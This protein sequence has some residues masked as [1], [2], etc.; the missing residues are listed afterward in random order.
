MVKAQLEARLVD[1]FPANLICVLIDSALASKAAA[2]TTRIRLRDETCFSAYDLEQLLQHEAFVHSH[3]ALNGRAQSTISC[4]GLGAP[5]N[6]GAQEGL[7]SFAE[8]ITGAIDIDRMERTALRV[9]G[10]D[11]AMRGATSSMCSDISLI[12]D[13][14]TAKASTRPCVYSAARR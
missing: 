5:R 9:V 12:P 14:R 4:L 10:T 3:T 7:A 8:L 2:G 1:V 6:T 13:N 11:M